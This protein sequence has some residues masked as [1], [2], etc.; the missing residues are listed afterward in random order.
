[1]LKFL[2][3]NVS[4]F[5]LFSLFF[6]IFFKIFLLSVASID[7]DKQTAAGCL[8]ISITSS[9][10]HLFR[11]SVDMMLRQKQDVFKTR[12]HFVKPHIFR[13]ILCNTDYD[14][15]PSTEESGIFRVLG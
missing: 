10:S 4:F 5:C 12:T 3:K 7:S 6:Q 9:S 1:M 8:P 15:S 13:I 2:F 11:I 14:R